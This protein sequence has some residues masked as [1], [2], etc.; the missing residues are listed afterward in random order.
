VDE[1][2]LRRTVRR[3]YD[4]LAETYD[5][6]RSEDSATVRRVERFAERLSAAPTVLDAGCGAGV[7]VASTLEGTA[8][9][10]DLSRET[11][12]RAA[13]TV[14]GAAL[15]QGEL[16]RLPLRSASVDGVVA[17][18]SVA[19]V[20]RAAHG[21]VFVEFARVPRPG[22]W[23]LVVLGTD[24]W[25]GRD[26]DWL[27]TG[28]EMAWSISGPERDREL[29]VAAGFDVVEKRRV[30]DELGGTFRHVTARLG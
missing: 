6:R 12:D 5:D 30:T 23:L 15:L 3:G 26:D 2:G 7:P 10:L 16:S 9:G 17:Y 19:H 22:G 1:D 18:Y 27:D 13:A 20:P 8:V 29:L 24:D 11:L 28:V 4:R 21:V 25:T 14:P